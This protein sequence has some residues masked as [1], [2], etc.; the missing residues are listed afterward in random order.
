M[1][2]PLIKKSEEDDEV[3]VFFS[4]SIPGI[5]NYIN[6]PKHFILIKVKSLIG[7]VIFFLPFSNEI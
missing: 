3:Y 7:L 5:S 6:Y 1:A 4:R 2:R